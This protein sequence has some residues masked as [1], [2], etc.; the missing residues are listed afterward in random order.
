MS[1][2]QAIEWLEL[3]AKASVPEQ[4][5]NAVQFIPLR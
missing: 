4:M 3:I 5:R 1:I 2:G